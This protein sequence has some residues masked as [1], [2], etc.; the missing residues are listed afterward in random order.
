[1]AQNLPHSLEPSPVFVIGSDRSGTSV[2]RECLGHGDHHAVLTFEPRIFCNPSASLRTLQDLTNGV[3]RQAL[4]D[5]HINRYEFATSHGRRGY[6]QWMDK[7]TYETAVTQLMDGLGAASERVRNFHSTVL[8]AL[9]AEKESWIDDTP[10]NAFVMEDIAATFP[11]AKFF[12]IIRDG[13]DVANLI[14][15]QGWCNRNFDRA[16]GLWISRVRAA[17]AARIDRTNYMEVSF[18]IFVADPESVLRKCADFLSI[19]FSSK[20]V[21]PVNAQRANKF[22]KMHTVAATKLLK[23]LAPDVLEEF[24][25]PNRDN[26]RGVE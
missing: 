1:M 3:K 5:Y 12:H 26:F 18:T 10:A 24:G 7:V 13:R 16:M 2:F 23:L 25:W 17:R 8:K 21:A 22:V 11:R 9:L 4:R 14:V 15:R 6:F 19:P 20:M